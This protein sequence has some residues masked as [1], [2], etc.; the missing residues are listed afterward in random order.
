M[1]FR[2]TIMVDIQAVVAAVE[3][4]GF[5]VGKLQDYIGN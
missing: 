4:Q 2:P 5:A 1:H 3:A